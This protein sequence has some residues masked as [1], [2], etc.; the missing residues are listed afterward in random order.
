MLYSLWK[1]KLYIHIKVDINCFK[2][3]LYLLST[4][5][6]FVYVWV[7]KERYF[8]GLYS[9]RLL[10]NFLEGTD[11]EICEV[12]HSYHPSGMHNVRRA[13]LGICIPGLAPRLLGDL[14]RFTA[15]N[16]PGVCAF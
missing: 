10:R 9:L 1:L 4:N 14:S 16:L 13:K 12:F 15:H 8:I 5:V 2:I 6:W 7:Y 11:G 3:N